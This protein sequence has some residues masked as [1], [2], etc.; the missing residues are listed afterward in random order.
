MIY[1]LKGSADVVS[2]DGG[3]VEDQVMSPPSLF[4][5]LGLLSSCSSAGVL[6]LLASS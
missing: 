1:S 5:F 4:V 3:I 2:V 6:S